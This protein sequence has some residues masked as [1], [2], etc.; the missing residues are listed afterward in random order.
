MAVTTRKRRVRRMYVGRTGAW[1]DDI[2]RAKTLSATEGGE[3]NLDSKKGMALF[4]L[5][6]IFRNMKVNTNRN[7]LDLKVVVPGVVGIRNR[8]G[9]AIKCDISI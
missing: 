4:F 7:S 2:R 1:R 8:K 6:N 3:K 9:G 5:Y